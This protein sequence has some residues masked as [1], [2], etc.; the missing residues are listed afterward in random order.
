MLGRNA[1]LKQLR[2]PKRKAGN[3][4]EATARWSHL[5]NLDAGVRL[6]YSVLEGGSGLTLRRR[7][8]RG[9]APEMSHVCGSLVARAAALASPSMEQAWEGR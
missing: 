8:C 5:V 9:V 3:K 7:V 2:S 1:W 6:G 4:K